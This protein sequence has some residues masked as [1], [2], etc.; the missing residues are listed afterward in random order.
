MRLLLGLG[1]VLVGAAAAQDEEDPLG[2][3][4]HDDTGTTTW[5]FRLG[6]FQQPDS[7]DGN[8]FLDEELTVIE[9]VVL[10]ETDLNPRLRGSSMFSYDN[11]SSA[12]IDRLS[13]FDGQSGASGDFYF[14]LDLGLSYLWDQATDVGGNLHFSKE[15]D[16]TSIGLGGSWGKEFDGGNARLKA[17]LS[18]YLDTVDL[19]RFDGVETGDD[20]RTTLSANLNWYQVLSPRTHGE[21]GLTLGAQSGYL[22]TPYNAVVI[23]D[24]FAPPNGNLDNFARGFEVTEELPDS[25]LRTA[26]HA[27][28][29]HRLS[30][31]RS[32]GLGARIYQDDWGITAFSLEPSWHQRLGDRWAVALRYRIYSQ[33][34]ADAFAHSFVVI[35]KERT[36][37]SDLGDFDAHT[38]GSHFTW[39]RS[40][41]TTWDFGVDYTDRSDGL[42]HLT[43]T[44]GWRYSF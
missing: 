24:P 28:V 32:I 20:D 38:L 43:A 44:I 40:E 37:D 42:N 14:G 36:Q 34:E 33:T 4:G 16:Y 19:I 25:R 17:S 27:K 3:P 41:S 21:V 13:K 30:E 31:G 6:L 18:A 22:E 29:R 15:Y 1:L 5:A 9:P 12:S 10:F 2:R 7:G 35:E 8:P 23:E 26:V 39:F 11:V